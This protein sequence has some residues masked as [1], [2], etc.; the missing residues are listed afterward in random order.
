M[1]DQIVW[2]ILKRLRVP[3]IVLILTFSIAITGLILIPGTDDA[4]NVYH[5]TFFDAFYFVSYMAST[6]GFGE[7][8]YT[9]NYEQRI[10]VS[11]CIYITVIGWFYGIGAIV[12]LIQDEALKKAIERNKFR[13]QILRLGEP[14]YIIFGYNVVTKSIIDRLNG[15]GYRIVVLD[16]NEDKI[17][18]LMLENFY[19]QVP[20]YV[21]NAT[22]QSVIKIAGIHQ[23]NC[24]GVISLFEDDM[25]N[26]QI[27]TLCKLLN[28]KIDIIVKATSPQQIEHF[29]NMDLEHIKNPF[30]IISDRLYYGITAPH[31]WLLE[32]WMY[33]LILKLRKKDYLPHGKYMVCGHGRMGQAIIEGLERAGIEY[34][35]YDV[36]SFE[37]KEKYNT[38]IF[39]SQ[40]DIDDL[41]SL[42]ITECDAIIAATQDD[43]F[44]LTLI[45]KAKQ[46]NPNLYTIAR[47]NSLEEYNIFQAAKI[48]KIYVVEKVLADATY[49]Y[50]AR[51][52]AD[53]FIHEARKHDEEW[54]EIIVNMLNNITG[55]NP[56]YFEKK[57]D[58]EGA[59]ALS[60]RLENDEKITLAD[61]RRSRA[62]NKEILKLVYLLLK[63][64][65]EVFLMP[66][67]S[68]VIEPEDELLVVA[69]DENYDDFEY[70]INN[71]YELEYVLEYKKTNKGT[72]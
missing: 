19:P 39:G 16:R 70:I 24:V 6:I 48:D 62:D 10:W 23:K 2:I 11:F 59:Y 33:G 57:I 60:M 46:L 32:M 61:I 29:Q 66:N 47:E 34:V 51:P 68:M 55:M 17:D 9:F 52:L 41:L 15:N 54:A 25:K 14:F 37:Y 72:A 42:G 1:H 49:N 31:I 13:K 28:K 53:I 40:E 18:E 5:M 58:K 65:D 26:S 44:N 56:H 7:A 71:Y 3:F 4:G 27:A 50:I 12:A 35:C 69:D 21:G 8:P 43:L 20:A 36:N 64:G 38:M 45:N 67:S 63:R 30:Q 22:N